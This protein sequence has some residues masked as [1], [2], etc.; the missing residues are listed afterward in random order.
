MV[1]GNNPRISASLLGPGYSIASVLAN[2]FSEATGSLYL[3]ALIELG[4]VLF[5]LTF[6]INGM[7]RLLILL[8][9][10]R[11]SGVGQ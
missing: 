1:I 3:S 5:L 4:L 9:T 7:A 6:I 11:G 10:Q 2:E 8:T